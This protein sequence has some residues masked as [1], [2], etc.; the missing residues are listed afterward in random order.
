ML[1]MFLSVQCMIEGL[2]TEMLKYDFMQYW[3]VT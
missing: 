3:S 2:E 1:A